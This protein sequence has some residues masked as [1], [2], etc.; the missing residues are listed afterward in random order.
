[1][2]PTATLAF[3]LIISLGLSGATSLYIYKNSVLDDPMMTGQEA[4]F[5]GW[6]KNA[7]DDFSGSWNDLVTYPTR[8]RPHTTT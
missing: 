7:Y 6:D 4:V 5:L 8:T 1:M 2:N 3:F